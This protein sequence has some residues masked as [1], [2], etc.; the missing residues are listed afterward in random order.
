L[1]AESG[2]FVG[3]YG[4]FVRGSGIGH[5]PRHAL[6]EQLV[7]E[8]ADKGGAMSAVDHIGLADELINAARAGRLIGKRMTARRNVIA[9]QVSD[10]TLLG[11]NEKQIDIRFSEMLT[12]I[13]KLPVN[14][15]PPFGDVRRCKPARNK[16]QVGRRK[17]AEM[18]LSGHYSG[19]P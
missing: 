9:L 18:I 17:R 19:G 6:S 13:G 2:F 14:V 12:N 11:M 1:G 10:R 15:G 4:A 5:D 16:R 3:A 8:G 7:N